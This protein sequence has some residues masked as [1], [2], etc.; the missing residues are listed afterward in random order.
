LSKE[1]KKTTEEYIDEAV[2]KT[3]RRVAGAYRAKTEANYY[4]AMEELL[5]AYPKRRHLMEHPEE[6]E[7][8]RT[9]KSK[10]ISIAPPAGTGVVDKIEV[11]AIFTEQR[12]AAYA[13]QMDLLNQTEFA[14]A[15]FKN[16]PEFA[17]IRM[18]YFNQDIHGNDRGA[19]AER[20]TWE[21]IE[22]AFSSIGIEKTVKVLRRWR[23]QLMREMVVMMFGA[24]GAVSVWTKSNTKRGKDENSDTRM[25]ES[26]ASISSDANG[27]DI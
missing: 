11:S 14:I 24:D 1:K 7:F 26:D 13:Y 12:K 15:P 20:M 21:D 9:G 25:A 17:V 18:I 22:E 8:Y 3:A 5:K 23:S 2:D 19:G 16:L 6:F 4:R 27:A 10:D